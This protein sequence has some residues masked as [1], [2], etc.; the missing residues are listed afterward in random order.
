ME[1][2]LEVD[3]KQ[4]VFKSEDINFYLMK[5]AHCSHC[6]DIILHEHGRHKKTGT[7]VKECISCRSITVVEKKQATQAG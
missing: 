7:E 2:L 4:P 5:P 3:N 1:K 6:N